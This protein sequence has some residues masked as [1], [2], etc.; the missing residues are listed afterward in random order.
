MNSYPPDEW[1]LPDI[2]LVLAEEVLIFDGLRGTLTLVVNADAT[3][4]NAYEAA[5]ARFDEI[6]ATL[7]SAHAQLSTINL[8]PSV[9]DFGASTIRY[10]TTQSEYEAWVERIREYILKGEVMQVVPSQRLSLP[11]KAPPLSLYRTFRNLNPSPYMYFLDLD[12]FEVIGSPPLRFWC[13]SRGVG[14]GS[15]DHRYTRTRCDRG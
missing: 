14:D 8:N 9:D 12:R 6:E 13:D 7:I 10:R 4:D 2:L 5:L 3:S 1:D 11:L 15:T